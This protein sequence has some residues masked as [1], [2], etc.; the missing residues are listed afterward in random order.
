MKYVR[1]GEFQQEAL[2]KPHELQ[3]KEQFT[4]SHLARI[5]LLL[6]M[7]IEDYHSK[8]QEYISDLLENYK[9][10]VK[11][12]NLKTYT[13]PTESLEDTKV[14]K[15]HHELAELVLNYFLS[16]LKITEDQDWINDRIKLPQRDYFRAFLLPRYQHV[17]TLTKTLGRE[18]GAKL[19]KKY[20]SRFFI[21]L[22]KPEEQD[23]T[24]LTDHYEKVS[25]E[26]SPPSDWITVRGLTDTGKYF[27]MNQNCLWVESLPEIEDKEL[28]YLIC[29]YGDYQSA[30]RYYNKHII[31]T[32]EHTI[33]QGDP[34]C[35]RMVHDTREDW[36]LRHPETKFWDRLNNEFPN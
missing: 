11:S 20:I 7:V 22:G 29:C 36:D 21:N 13:L 27:Y 33:A 5:D 6:S 1:V 28:M 35:S 24:N 16:L 34:Y 10:L 2:D 32:M 15:E 25:K 23:F 14:I 30:Q 8:F 17:K 9:S 12:S 19:Y 3:P 4:K 26:S 18:E 31:L